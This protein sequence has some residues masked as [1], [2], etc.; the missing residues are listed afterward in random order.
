MHSK[1][2]ERTTGDKS[3]TTPYN[4]KGKSGMLIRPLHQCCSKTL[5]RTFFV[6]KDIYSLQCLEIRF[7]FRIKFK[8]KSRVFAVYSL[9][10]IQLMRPANYKLKL[11]R[12]D[13]LHG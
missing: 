8:N 7:N 9:Q 1:V 13:M 12:H 10:N 6:T 3:I 11:L 4:I 5:L 2:K